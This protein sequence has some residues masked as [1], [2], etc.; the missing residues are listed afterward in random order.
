M[1]AKIIHL[2]DFRR[3]PLLSSDQISQR[4]S[5]LLDVAKCAQSNMRFMQEAA[6]FCEAF[7]IRESIRNRSLI[8]ANEWRELFKQNLGEARKLLIKREQITKA[9]QTR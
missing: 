7:G 5:V 3:N 6:K 9:S 1:T 8:L 4:I 2:S